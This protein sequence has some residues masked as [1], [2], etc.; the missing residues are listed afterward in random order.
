MTFP[1]FCLDED[2]LKNCFP[3]DP[4]STAS[5]AAFLSLLE[6]VLAVTE[7]SLLAHEQ[8][9]YVDV[10]GDGT[11]LLDVLYAD[12]SERDLWRRLM[13]TLGRCEIVAGHE[14]EDQPTR[15][16]QGAC[17]HNTESFG[18][19]NAFERS[20]TTGA[21]CGIA[22]RAMSCLK[23]G[24]AVLRI[25]NTSVEAH[26]VLIRKDIELTHRSALILSVSDEDSFFATMPK[27]FPK[28]FL[29]P[30]LSFRSFTDGYEG[31]IGLV[32]EHLSFLNDEFLAL[33]EECNWD[34]AAIL[35]RASV[36]MSD[37]SPN[38]K[39]NKRAMRQRE[40]K[41]GDKI[42]CCTLHTKLKPTRG[43]IHFH[44]PVVGLANDRVIIGI[45]TDHLDT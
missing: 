43:R 26:V 10:R 6:D 7:Q 31:S 4:E 24:T 29:V 12:S 27:A 5:F 35:A 17:V 8:V 45:F 36:A 32:C 39:A 18:I 11:L 16:E 34:Y 20:R 23:S 25:E 30:G 15:V 37:E 2:A 33:A 22:T 40:I 38:T 42:V 9:Y 3:A 19:R 13:I 14:V 21:Y 28:L 1:Q 44:P 41:I